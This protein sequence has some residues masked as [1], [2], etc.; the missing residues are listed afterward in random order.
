MCPDD[1]T[2]NQRLISQHARML[3]GD[4]AVLDRSGDGGSDLR[5]AFHFTATVLQHG[6][7]TI[8][9]EWVGGTALTTTMKSKIKF[10]TRAGR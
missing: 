8:D 6:T 7:Q 9:S 2:C 3:H 5:V 1:A 10:S 4:D